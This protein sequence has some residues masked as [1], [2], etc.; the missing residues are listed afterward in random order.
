MSTS[1][2]TQPA[3]PAVSDTPR[4]TGELWEE[5]VRLDLA[6][7]AE[8]P[9]SPGLV[10]TTLIPFLASKKLAFMPHVKAFRQQAS[11]RWKGRQDKAALLADARCVIAL[12]QVYLVYAREQLTK[13]RILSY[14]KC[15]NLLQQFNAHPDEIACAK[16]VLGIIKAD[17]WNSRDRE[18]H[19][20]LTCIVTDVCDRPNEIFP[21]LLKY[22]GCPP[23]P[24]AIFSLVS[25]VDWL[26]R[27]FSKLALWLE[28]DFYGA[29][30]G[31]SRSYAQ[32]VSQYV[33]DERHPA[34]RAK[35]CSASA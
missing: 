17:K 31:P 8:R 6:D 27:P 35:D 18:P 3:V 11:K 23:L 19:I 25:F 7:F 12:S 2:T 16:L 10:L 13:S 29:L 14:L 1:A 4:G 30:V 9:L 33:A 20:A 21:L 22:H 26:P 5:L 28:F 24:D 15:V 34:H 32:L